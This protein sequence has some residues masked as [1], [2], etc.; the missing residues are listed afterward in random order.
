M[1]SCRTQSLRILLAAG[2]GWLATCSGV[3]FAQGGAPV[4]A[5]TNIKFLVLEGPVEL[6]P[7]G[8]TAWVLTTTNQPLHS[9]DRLRTGP[10]TRMVLKWSDDSTVPVGALTE[11]EI[12]PPHDADAQAG[13]N[14]IRGILSFFHRDKPGRIRVITRGALAG[15]EGTEFVIA[16]ETTNLIERTT[17]SLIDG[18][19]R[20]YNDQGSLELTNNEQAFAEVGRP[21]V[22]TAGFIV[23]NVLQ[24]CFYYPGVLDLSELPLTPAEETALRESLAAYRAGDLLGA[25]RSYPAGRQP[26]SDAERLYYSAVLL[27]V[28]QVEQTEAAL[29]ALPATPA[30]GRIQRLTG[31]LRQLIAAVKRQPNPSTL[32]PELATELLAA[33]YYEQSLAVREK[34]LETALTLARRAA[35]N[36]PKFGFAWERVAEL[37]FSF[38]RTSRAEE[39][40]EKSYALSPRN[41]EALS[42]VGFL[43]AADNK[44]GQAID[45]FNYAI[46]A[47]PAL[48]N[49][50]LGRGL[51]RIR[52]GD[53]AGGREDLLVAAALEPQ[54]AALRS[55]LGKAYDDGNDYPRAKKELDRAKYLDPQD[56]TSWLYSAL[57]NQKDNRINE[58]IRDLEQAQELNDNRRIYRSA[59]KL[60][61]DRAVRSANLAA[62]YR[63]DGMIDLSV[64]E[65]SRAVSYD[66]ANYSAHLFLANSFDQLR[67]PNR[68]NLRYETPA[69]SEYLIANLLAPIQAGSLSPA[70][71]Q[72][73]YSR[74]FER[75]GFGLTSSTE[76]LSRG[77]WVQNAAQYG[78]F[79]NTS[80]DLEGFYRSDPGQRPNND[81]EE[82]SLSLQI[83]QQVSPQDTIFV[84]GLYY[85]A[86]GGD[87][88]QYYDQTQANP[89]L[90]TTEKQDPTLLIGYH[91]EWR[92]GLHTILLAGRLGDDVTVTNLVQ[93]TYF[94]IAPPFFSVQFM[95]IPQDYRSRLEIYTAELQQI[96]QTPQQNTVVGGRFQTGHLQTRNLQTLPDF[97]ENLGGYFALPPANAA[98][99]DE[100]TDLERFTFYAYH[101][102]QL[103][104]RLQLTAGLTYD[105][106]TFPEN[107]LAAPITNS[108]KT[109]DQFG[110]KAGLIWTPTDS[111]TLRAAYSRSLGGVSFDQSF[112]LEP[113]TVS[114]FLQSFRSIIPESI[115]GSE[116]GAEF[117]TFGLSLEQRF[118]F[119][120]YLGITAERLNSTV[121]RTVGMFFFDGMNNAGP[122]SLAERLDYTEKTLLLTVDQ[123]IGSQCSIGVRYRLSQA[124]LDDKFPGLDPNMPPGTY[125]DPF[126]PIQ[127]LR[128][129][130]QQVNLY[131]VFNHPSGWFAQF[132]GIW[133]GQSNHGYSTEMPGSYFWQ[134]NA[135]AGYRFWHRRAELRLGLLNLGDQDYHLNPLTLFNDLPRSR[136]LSIRLRFNF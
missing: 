77:A 82:K 56:P 135:F 66:Y 98:D 51:C 37:E 23:N 111:T 20:F 105:R 9:H 36:S 18:K 50:W 87:L 5:A 125:I 100:R 6:S 17:L 64:R 124:D 134:V 120:T 57:V 122:A 44:I 136:T 8:T 40:F 96:W 27:A 15:V 25:L 26:A 92:P 34:S 71:S 110:P 88:A 46:A 129:T 126:T 52:R 132:E 79:G 108:N 127:Q 114:G 119:G 73:E 76:Y 53:L 93:K 63:D 70:I 59:L 55:Y 13:L 68:I 33:S 43:L 58:A 117:E 121:D 69:D 12:L 131:S 83:K 65:A 112:R 3:S 130:L 84:Q 1:D 19:V 11:L 81:F 109:V 102:H 103:L 116:A 91:H 86:R 113:S 106:L 10:N 107:F 72:Q 74:L 14:L 95:T 54:R 7:A 80:Y 42:L 35:T 123:L 30:S 48:G 90:R 85:D 39:A 29:A 2:L 97:S 22:R 21:P 115:G 38:G 89:S 118:P 128:A 28:G 75:D 60:D 31:S 4:D 24:W 16:V 101:T 61:E 45:W 62:I 78:V 99:Q 104:A 47:D 32:N 67:D 133:T 94:E 41:A 49:A